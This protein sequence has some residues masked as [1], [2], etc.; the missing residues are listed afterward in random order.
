MCRCA[1]SCDGTIERVLELQMR[2]M[3]AMPGVQKATGKLGQVFVV[4]R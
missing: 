1:C 3:T 2:G 4:E